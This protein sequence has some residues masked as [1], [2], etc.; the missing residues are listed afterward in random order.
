MHECGVAS[1]L[2]Q[3]H[4]NEERNRKYIVNDALW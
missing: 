3:V 2:V 1:N 4:D